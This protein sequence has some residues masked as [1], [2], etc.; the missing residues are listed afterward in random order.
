MR[1]ARLAKLEKYL[2]EVLGTLNSSMLLLVLSMVKLIVFLV[3]VVHFI[4]CLWYSA[5]SSSGGWVEKFSNRDVGYMYVTSMHWSFSQFQGTSDIVPGQAGSPLVERCV[6]AFTILV[7]LVILSS[8]VSSL[9]NIMLRIQSVRTQM[10]AMDD[11]VRLFLSEN[12]ISWHLSL[13]VKK[14]VDWNQRLARGRESA[15]TV[16]EILPKALQIDLQEETRG[17]LIAVHKLFATL[18]TAHPR[19][20][21]Q[22][23]F[24][25]LNTLVPAPSEIIFNRD[26]VCHVMYFVTLGKY[27]YIEP[28]AH[29]APSTVT[30]QQTN[31]M[32]AMAYS[33][34]DEKQSL[35]DENDHQITDLR[36]GAYLSEACLWTHWEHFGVLM[37]MK[38][39]SHMCME[40]VKL[41]RIAKDNPTGHASIINY[42]R[43]FVGGLNRFGK[44]FTDLIDNKELCEELGGGE[45]PTGRKTETA[46][47]TPRFWNRSSA[48]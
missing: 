23:C 4:A 16:L 36:P 41:S 44:K 21:R 7:S 31:A 25:A 38:H 30:L 33:L 40:Q 18:Q 12:D 35:E 39:C 20:F 19:V 2:N 37:G 45:A 15:S 13:R 10:N 14:Y 26:E 24:D 1:L 8:F 22:I 3:V 43:R 27:R 5:G 17:P 9:T 34:E 42:A 48:N 47:T 6:A 29:R 11:A 28:L 46:S 32:N